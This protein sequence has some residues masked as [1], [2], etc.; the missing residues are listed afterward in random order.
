MLDTETEKRN[1]Y[2]RTPRKYMHIDTC[3]W[4]WMLA[5]TIRCLCLQSN[6]RLDAKGK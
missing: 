1:I 6:Y 4:Y 5:S 2:M 3:I